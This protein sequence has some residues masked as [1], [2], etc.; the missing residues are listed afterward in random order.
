MD[1]CFLRRKSK[2]LPM[3][4][5]VFL[6]SFDISVDLAVEKNLSE[7]KTFTSEKGIQLDIVAFQ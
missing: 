3:F 5:N 6:T 1:T 7:L 4:F 2:T